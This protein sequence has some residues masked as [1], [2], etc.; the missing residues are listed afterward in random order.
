MNHRDLL[1]TRLMACAFTSILVLPAL[2]VRTHAQDS[3]QVTFVGD[4]ELYLREVDKPGDAPRSIA[5]S[6]THLTLPT[7]A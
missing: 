1:C 7:K 2:T 6:Y 3:L 4:R 5:V